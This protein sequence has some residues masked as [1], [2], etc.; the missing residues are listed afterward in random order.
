MSFL[1]W[2]PETEILLQAMEYVFSSNSLHPRKAKANKQQ[3]LTANLA[4]VL[5]PACWKAAVVKDLGL[6]MSQQ[7]VLVAKKASRTLGCI[8]KSI[9]SRLREVILPLYSALV[10]PHLECPVLGSSV[11]ERQGAP[12]ADPAEGKEDS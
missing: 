2:S 8:R 3:T 5:G 10:R 11:P 6:S 1:I 12:G 7:S 9:A 4:S